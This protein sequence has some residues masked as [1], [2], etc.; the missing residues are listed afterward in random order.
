VTEIFSPASIERLL[1]DSREALRR[2]QSAPEHGATGGLSTGR[3][4]DEASDA[5][6]RAEARDASAR[7]TAVV[8]TPGRI[9]SLQLD[10][11][12][13][14]DGSEAVCDAITEAVNIALAK[15]QD[16]SVSRAGGIDTAA[17]AIDLERLQADSLTSA[18][19][20]MASLQDA[21]TRISAPV[22]RASS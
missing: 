8:T 2:M 18:T 4:A 20:M 16:E 21:M 14:R 19:T 12:L 17:L 9:E 7:V 22:S 15:L 10:P 3:D 13:M 11:R 6:L 5:L 1:S